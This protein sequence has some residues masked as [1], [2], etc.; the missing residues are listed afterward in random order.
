[1]CVEIGIIDDDIEDP[2]L[3][4]FLV[5]LNTSDPITLSPQVATVHIIDD[6]GMFTE[7]V[8]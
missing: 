8:E 3:H 7:L 2:D 4:D 1:M 6:E 5:R